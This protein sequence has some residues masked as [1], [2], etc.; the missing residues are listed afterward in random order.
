MLQNIIVCLEN[1]GYQGLKSDKSSFRVDNTLILSSD[2]NLG[3]KVETELSNFK[4]GAA[5]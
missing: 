2:A 5:T 1:N 3:R 4:R